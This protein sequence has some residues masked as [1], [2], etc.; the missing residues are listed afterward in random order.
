M[1]NST[2]SINNI[3]VSVNNAFYTTADSRRAAAA[4][5]LAISGQGTFSG[6]CSEYL[7]KEHAQ[8]E[9]M[10]VIAD[11][12]TACIK[13]ARHEKA[14]SLGFAS[15]D[16]LIDG[17]IDDEDLPTNKKGDKKLSQAQFKARLKGLNVGE[18]QQ[19]KRYAVI[20]STISR[21]GFA[22][23]FDSEKGTFT[24]DLKTESADEDNTAADRLFKQIIKLDDIQLQKLANLLET[25][26]DSQAVKL[27]K[28][29]ARQNK[30]STD[31][32]LAN[33]IEAIRKQSKD[34]IKRANARISAAVQLKDKEAENAARLSHAQAAQVIQTV[35]E[36]KTQI[37]SAKDTGSLGEAFLH[38]LAQAEKESKMAVLPV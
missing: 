29:I 36:L 7:D 12:A 2:V 18:A 9:K 26:D 8:P 4:L 22:L 6:F 38:T 37:A 11:F 10:A 34:T 35:S 19:N 28:E 27:I 33:R 16:D 24:V 15:F 13:E 21:L 23:A 17:T 25:S 1:S 3:K 20:K 5:T 31:N 14:L 30:A 32:T